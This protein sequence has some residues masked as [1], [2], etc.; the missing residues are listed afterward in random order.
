MTIHDMLDKGVCNPLKCKFGGGTDAKN[1]GKREQQENK[2][3]TNEQQD[4]HTH[5]LPRRLEELDYDIPTIV[6]S[7]WDKYPGEESTTKLHIVMSVL[8]ELHMNATRLLRVSPATA[9][10]GHRAGGRSLQ[11]YEGEAFLGPRQ[12]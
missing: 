10:A 6:R 5:K 4:T 11:A 1:C 12:T 3:E 8:Q 9:L 2:D 7:W